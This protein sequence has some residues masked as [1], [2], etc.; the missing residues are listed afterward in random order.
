MI[1][2]IIA[3]WVLGI[4]CF[5]TCLYAEIQRIPSDY[6]SIQEGIDAATDGD[7]VLVSEGTYYERIDFSGKPISVVSNFIF[8]QDSLTIMNTII[9]ADTL[10]LGY[11]D[12]GNVVSFTSGEDSRSL[13]KG[14]TIT[15]G[16]GRKEDDTY[17][18]GGIYC[19]SSSPTIES[20]YILENSASYPGLPQYTDGCGGG[21]YL[22]DCTPIVRFN[23]IKR[24]EAFGMDYYW[25]VGEGGGIYVEGCQSGV[26]QNNI[27]MNNETG[28]WGAGIYCEDSQVL[29]RENRIEEN[30][31]YA[32]G[33]GIY[34]YNSSLEIANNTIKRNNE[35][36]ILCDNNS[37]AMIIGN[38]IVGNE[39]GCGIF[40]AESSPTILNNSIQNNSFFVLS[41]GGGIIFLYDSHPTIAN[42]IIAENRCIG[43]SG[44]LTC[45]P[46]IDYNDVW[47]NRL[48]DYFNCEPGERDI[49]CDPEFIDP[50]I[51]EDFRLLPTSHCIDAGDPE[52]D[53]PEDGGDRVD[54]G[55]YEYQQ[56]YNGF[57]ILSD[58]PE[59]A[60]TGKRIALSYTL[61][62]PLQEPVIMDAWF[63]FTG[64][65]CVIVEE[66]LDITIPP[67]NHSGTIRLLIPDDLPRGEYTVK[68]RLGVFGE[69]IWDSEV[70]DLHIIPGPK[71]AMTVN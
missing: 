12:I 60:E 37:N 35:G 59:I 36:G 20:N 27:I 64:P 18:G 50:E 3:W 49:S 58:T 11:S 68:G 56:L 8:T 61:S 22:K 44:D 63:D 21:I 28:C 51:T 2:L 13:L 25:I 65:M 69:E 9:N 31:P 70:F 24:N 6:P 41:E 42:N 52:S 10:I 62:N 67:R 14:F 1:K 5:G 54:I 57:L 33:G 38:V 53:V 66:F 45:N 4:V 23:S 29:I 19:V 17:M 43:L 34:C 39:D 71:K 15:K 16:T 46:I 48:G 55:A 40:I 26:I 32:S 7:T 30:V 47:D